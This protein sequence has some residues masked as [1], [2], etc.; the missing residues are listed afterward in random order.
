MFKRHSQL[1]FKI[2]NDDIFLIV[3]FLVFCMICRKVYDALRC[4]TCTVYSVQFCTVV[5]YSVDCTV[6]YSVDCTVLY[7]VDCTVL[8]CRFYSVD[9]TVQIVKCILYIVQCRLYSVDYTVQILR[10]ELYSVDCTVQ[11]WFTLNLPPCLS[12]IYPSINKLT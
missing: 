3:L 4:T 2:E 12:Q 7:S 9:C 10:C 6:L 11:T 8:Q 1:D 5:L